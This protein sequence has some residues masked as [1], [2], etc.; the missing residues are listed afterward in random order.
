MGLPDRA[1]IDGQINPT[2]TV[3]GCFSAAVDGEE[4]RVHLDLRD[5]PGLVPWLDS[6]LE[7]ILS[8]QCRSPEIRPIAEPPGGHTRRLLLDAGI[9]YLR[10]RGAGGMELGLNPQLNVQLMLNVRRHGGPAY[11]AMLTLA[12]DPEL[13]RWLLRFFSDRLAATDLRR[14][15]ESLRESLRGHNLLVDT[16]PAPD[17]FW[18]D[19]AAPVELAAELAL[20]ARTSRQ[21][22]GRPIPAEVRRVLGRHTPA[23]P[24]DTELVWGEDTGTGMVFPTRLGADDREAVIARYIGTAASERA[25]QWELQLEAARASV[26]NRRHAVLRDIVPAPQRAKLRQFVRQLRERG[27]FPELGDGQ[28]ALRSSIHNQPTIASLHQGLAGIVS[29]IGKEP[30]NPSYCYL[31]CYEEGAVLDRHLDRAQCAYNLCLVLDMQY[32]DRDGDPEPWP[33]Y[34]ELDGRPEA[35][36][37]N[38]GDGVFFSGSQIWHWRDALPAGQRAFVCFYHFVPLGYTGSLD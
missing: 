27:Y 11:Q 32:L 33:I 34:L 21:P 23:L 1:Q 38:V 29:R 24:P 25:T 15:G 31:S 12:D 20:A 6:I 13:T 5:H 17:A 26:R 37:L 35:A 14:L 30:V 19:P 16:L 36:L 8:Q 18:P 4:R 7:H 28:V 9:L 10:P 22:A 3:H 2:L